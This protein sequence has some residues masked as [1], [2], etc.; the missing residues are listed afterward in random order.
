M[1]RQMK[2]QRRRVR[3]P[4]TDSKAIHKTSLV[5]KS[6]LVFTKRDFYE[7]RSIDLLYESAEYENC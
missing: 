4:R 5:V 7:F 6:L 1:H 2:K 3:K